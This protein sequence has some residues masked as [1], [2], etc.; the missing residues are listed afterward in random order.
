M[1]KS[2]VLSIALLLMACLLLLLA[3]CAG[4]AAENGNAISGIGNN[5]SIGNSTLPGMGKAVVKVQEVVFGC[6]TEPPG[7]DTSAC[8]ARDAEPSI[9]EF[10]ISVY[11]LSSVPQ[12]GSEVIS[13]YTAETTNT[14]GPVLEA[15]V[16]TDSNGEFSLDIAPGDYGFMIYGRLGGRASERFTISS[17]KITQVGVNYTIGVPGAG[18]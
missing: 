1:E 15:R 8:G 9:G 13:I 2:P 6:G 5:A 3:G 11:S 10:N 16:A 12:G 7:G 4:T 14:A 17:G 18:K